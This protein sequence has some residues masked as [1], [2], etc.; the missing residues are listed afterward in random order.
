VRKR[1]AIIEHVVASLEE[2]KENLNPLQGAYA[3]DTGQ[4]VVKLED[5][6]IKCYT[7]DDD[8]KRANERC[9]YVL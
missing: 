8:M 6:T 4:W 2:L 9:Y 7:P 3:S 5:G 1:V